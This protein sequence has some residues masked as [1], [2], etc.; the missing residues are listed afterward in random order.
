MKISIFPTLL[1]IMATIA[2]S[3]LAF[4]MAHDHSD[5]NEL[6]VGIGTGL[7]VILTLGCMLSISL[8]D[9]RMNINMKAWSGT[10]FLVLITTNLCFAGFGVTLP[11]YLIVIALLLVIHLW[12]VY[13]LAIE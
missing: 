9:N 5:S 11:Y 8:K 3:Y 13:K 4:N 1:L 7:S 12:V 6:L 10:A 2:L